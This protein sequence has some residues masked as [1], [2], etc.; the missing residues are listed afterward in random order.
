MVQAMKDIYEKLP[1]E[2]VIE[3]YFSLD[4][5]WKV[6]RANDFIKIKVLGLD[7]KK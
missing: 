1:Y 6:A 2:C 3:P 5:T 7:L 4:Q